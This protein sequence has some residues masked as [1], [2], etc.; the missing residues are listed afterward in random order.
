MTCPLRLSSIEAEGEFH[1]SK[2]LKHAALLDLE[3]LKS[4]L[5]E[6][7]PLFLVPAG[8]L[9]TESSWEI[10]WDEFFAQYQVY[11]RW[12]QEHAELPPPAMRRFFSLM[13]TS[14]LDALYAI[15]LPQGKMIVKACLPVIQVQ[16]YHCF[17]SSVDS[18]IRPMIIG[19]DSF[20]WGLQIS[21]PQIH[22]NP[23]THE[24]A[25]VLLDPGFPNTRPF[26]AMVSWLRKNSQPVPLEMPEGKAYAPFRMGKLSGEKKESHAGLQKIL[27]RKRKSH[28]N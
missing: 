25:K 9:V 8:G 6:A 16:L 2:W 3:E 22:Q 24:F 19:P 15:P 4:F 12:M 17:F 28:E 18:Q 20:S 10:S 5:S 13:L 26:K 21:Y 1:V 23:K 27:A 7:G 11:L 14:S